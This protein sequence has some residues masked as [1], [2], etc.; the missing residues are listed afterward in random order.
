MGAAA[1]RSYLTAS[2]E[3]LTIQAWRWT[4]GTRGRERGLC[5]MHCCPG[6]LTSP[7]P[8]SRCGRERGCPAP[9]QPG[10]TLRRLTPT[11]TIQ[12]AQRGRPD[13]TGPS[14][15]PTAEHKIIFGWPIRIGERRTRD[16]FPER[17]RLAS[18]VLGCWPLRAG[19]GAPCGDRSRTERSPIPTDEHTQ[20]A[21][22]GGRG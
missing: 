2:T 9:T 17:S 1:R 6:R 8:L 11:P 20:T 14:L 21:D 4:N 13:R 3:L 22:P 5:G 19:C 18:L 12:R 7:R 10:R 16:A 15:I